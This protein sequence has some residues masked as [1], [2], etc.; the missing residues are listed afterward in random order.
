MRNLLFA[1]L[2]AA[3]PAGMPV[4]ATAENEPP[5][6]PVDET[7]ESVLD[8]MRFILRAIPQY[9]MPEVL[10]NGDIIIRR[11]QPEPKT[12]PERRPEDDEDGVRT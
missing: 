4:T 11:V 1:A 5:K 7:L 3:L 8:T 10:P 12:E 6:G 9:E 2:I